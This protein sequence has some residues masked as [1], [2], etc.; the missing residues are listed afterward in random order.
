MCYGGGFSPFLERFIISAR[1][2]IGSN[3]KVC[4]LQSDQGTEFTGGYTQQ[5]LKQENIECQFASSPQYATAQ[6]RRRTI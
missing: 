4:Y 6:R 5:Y 2:M 3:E 1:N